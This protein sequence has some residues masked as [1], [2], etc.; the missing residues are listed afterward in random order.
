MPTQ[1]RPLRPELLGG[2]LPF[3]P[4]STLFATFRGPKKRIFEIPILA[5]PSPTPVLTHPQI[6]TSQGAPM[7]ITEAIEAFETLR[8]KKYPN[9]DVAK[10]IAT[11]QELGLTDF[12]VHSKGSSTEKFDY[13]YDVQ[14]ILHIHPTMLVAGQPYADSQAESKYDKFPHLFKLQGWIED[15]EEIGGVTTVLC[16]TNFTRVPVNTECAC[17]EVHQVEN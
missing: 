6:N 9:A 1:P 16:P 4:I 15:G 2:F 13:I 8:K 7:N 11:A 12:V 17:G 14:H 10:I 5:N 3:C